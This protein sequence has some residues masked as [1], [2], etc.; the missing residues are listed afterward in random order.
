MAG[1]GTVIDLSTLGIDIA[2][3][4]AT[5]D[6]ARAACDSEKLKN[7]RA[8]LRKLQKEKKDFASSR[9]GKKPEKEERRMKDFDERIAHVDADVS[10]LHKL[11]NAKNEAEKAYYDELRKLYKNIGLKN[12]FTDEVCGLLRTILTTN[13]GPTSAAWEWHKNQKTRPP[14]GIPL[15]RVM[16]FKQEI[17][18]NGRAYWAVAH[19]HGSP[20][21]LWTY[22]NN[23]D[24][25]DIMREHPLNP[26][27]PNG[28]LNNK[29]D[30][31]C[32]KMGGPHDPAGL[33]GNTLGV[34]IGNK[35]DTH[36]P[37]TEWGDALG[38]YPALAMDAGDYFDAYGY[39]GDY[40][41]EFVSQDSLSYPGTSWAQTE[42]MAMAVIV[43]L[44]ACVLCM[45]LTF[46]AGIVAGFVYSRTADHDT[47][48]KVA[49]GNEQQVDHV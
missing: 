41:P 19:L 23:G 33:L 9:T 25:L 11:D 4:T 18:V 22:S 12:K 17:S 38:P 5:R 49:I 7:K 37:A 32:D 29:D 48:E 8:E 24:K 40:Q 1:G 27:G 34:Q 6:T 2:G 46:C 36:A 42:I 3:K 45:F 35:I 30:R 31:L 14:A 21:N 28:G 13:G 39:D 16:Y 20:T 43:A 15:S 26:G 10:R 47:G 44:L